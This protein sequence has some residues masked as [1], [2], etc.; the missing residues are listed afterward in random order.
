M[1]YAKLLTKG[2]LL[3]ACF[4]R[5]AMLSMRLTGKPLN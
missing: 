2:E 5:E 1:R 4:K 3:E